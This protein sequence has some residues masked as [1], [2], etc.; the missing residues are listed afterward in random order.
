MTLRLDIAVGPVQGFVLQSR[1][2]RDLWGSSYLLSFL[3]GHAMHGAEQ[4]GGRI[5]QPMVKGDTLYRWTGGE[6]VGEPPSIGS[7]PNHFAVDVEAEA[8]PVARAAV[9][10]LRG[11]WT[12]I[13]NA[14]WGKFVAEACE[15]GTGTQAIWDRQVAAFW[16]VA[17][18]AGPAEDGLLARRKHWRSH[19]PPTEPGDKCTVMHDLQE[20]SGHVRSAGRAGRVSQDRFWEYLR[21]R[22]GAL[23][24]RDNERLCA[25]A[26]IKRLFPRVADDALGWKEGRSRWPS[27]VHIAARPWL[28]RVENCAPDLARDYAGQVMQFAPSGVLSERWL[29]RE[30]SAAG[31]FPRLDANWYHREA[32]ES[33]R[34]CPLDTHA[35]DGARANLAGKLKAICRAKDRNGQ[36][37]GPP[38][39][40]YALLLADGDQLGRLVGE[41]G[42]EQVSRALAAFMAQV[43]EIVRKHGG[44]TVYAGGDDALALLPVPGALPCAEEMAECYRSA[45]R[46]EVGATLSAAVAFV[47]IRYPLGG[48]LRE[49]R[50]LLDEVAK[51]GNGRDSL[52]V[53]V[54][55][56]GGLNSQWV[57]TWHRPRPDGSSESSVNL[58][59]TQAD[60][61]GTETSEPD[62][63]SALLYRLRE[64]LVRLGGWDSWRPGAWGIVP[65]DIDLPAF[66]CAEIGH[67]LTVIRGESAAAAAAEMADLVGRLLRRAPADGQGG[68]TAEIGVDALLLARF[69][70]GGGHG[71]REA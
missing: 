32:V 12:R 9:A 15:G 39:S 56:P 16:E 33:T 42:G 45:F 19:L 28:H 7:L 24:L 65:E 37:L 13:C 51:E 71:E 41:T 29:D 6:R 46:H 63:S 50:R 18:C 70:A 54:L 53:G 64:L 57:T 59:R 34:L 30:R 5:V 40:F 11:A 61:L 2:T 35:G 52:A 55:K 21:G 58:V 4:A 69:L 26:L 1:R 60:R 49:A 20:L 27:T 68:E 14:V 17:W 25:I 62:L 10:A 43:L 31:N 66:L 8:E 48:A 47:H 36:R 38:S 3:A 67:S 22:V 23:D 44:E